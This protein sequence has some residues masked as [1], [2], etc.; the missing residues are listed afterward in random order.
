MLE[1]TTFFW[2]VKV[3]QIDY[4]QPIS[5]DLNLF[6]A[7]VPITAFLDIHVKPESL[8]EAPDVIHDTLLATRAFDGCLGVD[9]LVD[10][11]D[12]THFV[13]VEKW[14]SLDHDT[15]YRTYRAGPGKSSLGTILSGTPVLTKFEIATD[16]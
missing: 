7:L 11:E 4:A 1:Y 6:G 12:P 14:I 2:S 10:T 9:V 3:C 8:A 13:L 16:I 5:R 15:A